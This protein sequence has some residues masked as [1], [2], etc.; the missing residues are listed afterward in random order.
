MIHYATWLEIQRDHRL[1]VR[2]IYKKSAEALEKFDNEVL[3]IMS[4]QPDLV[5]KTF[6]VTRVLHADPEAPY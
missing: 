6:A 2:R 4:R 1:A 3:S 5:H